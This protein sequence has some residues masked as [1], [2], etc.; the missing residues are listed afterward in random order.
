MQKSLK[1]QIGFTIHKNPTFGEPFFIIFYH[2]LQ[3]HLNI[4]V[5]S[6]TTTEYLLMYNNTCTH[7]PVELSIPKKLILY[8]AGRYDRYILYRPTNQHRY[9][10][11]FVPEKIPTVLAKSGC[12]GR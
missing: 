2:M 5:T 11:C 4:D 1:I 12:F 8:R 7:F 10:L 6:T 3:L 9:P